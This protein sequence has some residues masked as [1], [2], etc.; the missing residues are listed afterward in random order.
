MPQTATGRGVGELFENRIVTGR[1]GVL[2]N[3]RAGLR[4]GRA[5]IAKIGRLVR[6]GDQRRAPTIIVNFAEITE[7]AHGRHAEHIVKTD[8]AA[9]C[10]ESK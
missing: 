10:R 6:H 8:V 1:D 3:R 4:S 5:A 9:G 2:V 7:F